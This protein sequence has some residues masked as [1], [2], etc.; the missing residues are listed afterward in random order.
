MIKMALN[1]INCCAVLW[2]N[3]SDYACNH[4]S[5][6]IGNETLR[7]LEGARGTPSACTVSEA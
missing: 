2:K 1:K 5:P 4:G 3:I 7:P 6:R